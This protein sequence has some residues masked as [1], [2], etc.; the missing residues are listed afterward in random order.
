MGAM[1]SEPP[2][3]KASRRRRAARRVAQSTR[4]AESRFLIPVS[5]ARPNP[6]PL[7]MVHCP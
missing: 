2:A 7:S 1:S 6:L 3:A 4:E 5:P